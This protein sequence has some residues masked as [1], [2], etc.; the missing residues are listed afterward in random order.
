[1][2]RLDG[3]QR[4]DCSDSDFQQQVVRQ[5]SGKRV[6]AMPGIANPGRFFSYLESLGL[7]FRQQPRSDHHPFVAGDFNSDADTLYF[8]TEK[9][10]VK[11]RALTID[12]SR[13]WYTETEATMDEAFE[14]TFVSHVRDIIDR[15]QQSLT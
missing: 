4:I 5:F 13:I 11:C 12:A 1:M 6:I 7:D 2:C 10:K 8:L 14:D 3:A 9:D 15:K